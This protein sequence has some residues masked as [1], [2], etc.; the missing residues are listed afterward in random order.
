MSRPL[1][2]KTGETIPAIRARRGDFED[3]IAAG[4]GLARESI[5]V[6]EVCR[7]AAL[8]KPAAPRAVI[9]TGSSAL[10]TDREDWS[11]RTAD[12]LAEAA[13]AGTPVLGICYGHQLLAHALGGVVADD[14]RGREIGTV[15]LALRPE[16]AQDPL[17]RVLSDREPVHATHLQSVTRLPPGAR[18]LASSPG[19]PNHAFAWGNRGY[20][21]KGMG[22]MPAACWD[23]RKACGLDAQVTCGWVK[24][25]CRAWPAR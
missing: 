8:P 20:L 17:L 15:A 5:D 10:V 1:I 14:P 21:R 25:Q 13:G 18:W 9:V 23:W 6:A 19:D 24:D 7:G 11:E 22:D 4:L 2:V 16:A 3:W 12:W